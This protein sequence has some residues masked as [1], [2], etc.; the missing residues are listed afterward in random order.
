MVYK[1]LFSDKVGLSDDFI[2]S[3]FS[4]HNG[5]L[6]IGTANGGLNLLAENKAKAAKEQGD[7]KSADPLNLQEV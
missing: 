4:D 2:N 5:R 6:W 3:L 1:L 7:D